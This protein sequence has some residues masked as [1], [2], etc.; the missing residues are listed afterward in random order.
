[1]GSLDLA[2]IHGRVACDDAFWQLHT[3]LLIRDSCADAH[4]T[5]GMQDLARHAA[6]FI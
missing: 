4:A 1:M 2:M 6:G 3:V 5:V